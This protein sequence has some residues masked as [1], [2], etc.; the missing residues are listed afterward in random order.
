MTENPLSIRRATQADAPA[1]GRLGALLWRV[2]HEWDTRR[3][4]APSA[5]PEADYSAFL[6]SQLRDE[7]AAVFVGERGGR[8]VGYVFASLEPGSFKELRAACGY[9]HDI[10]VLD[11]ERRGGVATALIT[12]ARE[13]LRGRGVPRV[14]LWTADANLGAQQLFDRLGFRRTMIEM[15]FD[16]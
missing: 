10:A 7:N 14:V 16:L 2:H 5:D 3:F 11:D 8:A 4:I 9:I 13:W 1:L 15:T 6:V 12:T